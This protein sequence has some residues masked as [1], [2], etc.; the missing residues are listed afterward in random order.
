[1]PPDEARY[2]IASRHPWAVPALVFGILSV[3]FCGFVAAVPAIIVGNKVK[4]ETSA[5]GGSLT[6]AGL[7]QAGFVL[8]VIGMA[9]SVITIVVRLFA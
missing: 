5:S 2:F 9:L 1:M 8:G 4:R 6:G 7:G 3:T